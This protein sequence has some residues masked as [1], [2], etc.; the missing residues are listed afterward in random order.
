[1]NQTDFLLKF[2][3]FRGMHITS[4]WNEKSILFL[5]NNTSEDI[6]YF[7]LES[8]FLSLFSRHLSLSRCVVAFTKKKIENPH[9]ASINTQKEADFQLQNHSGRMSWYNQK[10][11]QTIT[12]LY[13]EISLIVFY[14]HN[15]ELLD[16]C[17]SLLFR[18]AVSLL[19]FHPE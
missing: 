17:S 3:I 11:G 10:G 14:S 8:Y 18:F 7:R 9:E 1:M 4:L 13:R 12:G 15:T 2:S 19:I 6:L 16:N 5:R